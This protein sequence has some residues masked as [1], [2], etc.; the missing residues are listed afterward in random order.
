QSDGS[1]GKIE[2]LA[3]FIRVGPGKGCRVSPVPDHLVRS[4]PGEKVEF[5][6]MPGFFD[7]APDDLGVASEAR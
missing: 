2:F 4:L 6:L 5:R 3:S 1:F 7:Y